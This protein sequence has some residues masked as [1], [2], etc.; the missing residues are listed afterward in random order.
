MST[1]T[2]FEKEARGNSE[3]AYYLNYLKKSVQQLLLPIAMQHLAKLIANI[4]ELQIHCGLD[5]F[6]THCKPKMTN[7]EEHS[8]LA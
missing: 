2:R 7:K 1:R 6:S 5:S 3:M 8:I 4:V